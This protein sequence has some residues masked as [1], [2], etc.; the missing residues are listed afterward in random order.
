[1]TQCTQGA[2]TAP[3]LISSH[4]LFINVGTVLTIPALLSLGGTTTLSIPATSY[5]VPRVL[6]AHTPH[7]EAPALDH[8]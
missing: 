6:L 4:M 3:F 1:M 8:A 2:T 5:N 7:V